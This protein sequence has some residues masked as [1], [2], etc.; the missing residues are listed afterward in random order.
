[1]RGEVY[2]LRAPRDPRG[3]EQQGQRYGVVVQADH[4]TALS[5]WLVAPTSTAAS[6]ASYRPEA[7]VNGRTTRVI[8]EQTTAL[9]PE[10]RLG[11]LVGRLRPDELE[12]V[13][14]ALRDVLG[15]R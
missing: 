5:T 1:M 7:Q 2:R 11:E 4:L 13:D 14:Q 10:R 9:D 6:P 8:V 12:A 3:H 15:L